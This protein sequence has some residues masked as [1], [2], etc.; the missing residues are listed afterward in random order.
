MSGAAART[1][2]ERKIIK[3]NILNIILREEQKHVLQMIMIVW[4]YNNIVDTCKI[5]RERMRDY[6]GGVKCLYK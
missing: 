3:I 1:G 6:I 5:G 2:T 4:K